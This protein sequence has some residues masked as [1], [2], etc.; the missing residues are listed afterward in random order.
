MRRSSSPARGRVE[1]DDLP[2][3]EAVVQQIAASSQSNSAALVRILE[4]VP[5][6]DARVNAEQV[7]AAAIAGSLVL[8]E[9]CTGLRELCA[10]LKPPLIAK[11]SAAAIKKD[12]QSAHKDKR[13]T[14]VTELLLSPKSREA[15]GGERAVHAAAVVAELLAVLTRVGMRTGKTPLEIAKVWSPALN[16]DPMTVQLLLIRSTAPP[17]SATQPVSTA[18]RALPTAGPRPTPVATGSTPNPSKQLDFAG[19]GGSGQAFEVVLQREGGGFGLGIGEDPEGG[20]PV[21]TEVAE[22][23]AAEK[24][25]APRRI[26][27]E[28]A[29]GSS[30]HT[31]LF[32]D[33]PVDE[34]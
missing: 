2:V 6:K 13:P 12:V 23:G 14:P 27:F 10:T 32:L 22:S 20:L 29:Q 11:K 31:P 30:G 9:C 8:T 21:I 7:R 25:G 3:V 16:L 1:T 26:V 15:A 5:P 17:A 34:G 24:T 18:A 28:P 19:E 4:V 33:V